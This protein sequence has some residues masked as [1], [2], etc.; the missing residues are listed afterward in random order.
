MPPGRC[1]NKDKLNQERMRHS[2]HMMPQAKGNYLRL[3]S[4]RMGPWVIQ[5]LA[6]IPKPTVS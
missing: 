3:G 6:A 1:R 4:G 2:R 5:I